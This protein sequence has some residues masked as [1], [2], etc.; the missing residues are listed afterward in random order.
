[1]Q[2]DTLIINGTIIDG[3]CKPKFK[4][5]IGIVNGK[6]DKI[7]QFKEADAKR[8]INAENLIISPGFIDM[9]TH[10]DI[11]L[12]ND[13]YGESKVYQG[14][15]TEVTGNCSYSPFPSGKKGPNHLKKG[16]WETGALA[17]DPNTNWTWN[18]LDD[19]ANTIEKN[20][21]SINIAPQ[22][23]YA[24]L[25]VATGAT[26]ERPASKT[27]MTEMK[28]LA[29]QAI[30]Q[31]AFSISTGLSVPPSAYASTEEVI[32]ICKSISHYNG[33][34]YVTHARVGP[35]KHLSMIEEAVK[36]GQKSN[37]PVQFSHLAI[38]DWRY[39]GHGPNMLK[40]F[41]EADKNGLDITYD[42]YPYTAAGAGLDQMIPLWAQSGGIDTFLE[43]LKNKNKRAQIREEVQEGIGGLAPK[44]ET[45]IL[46]SSNN[47]KN[48]E[49]IGMSIIQIAKKRKIDPAETA[50]QLVEEEIGAVPVTVHNRLESDIRCF[51]DHPLAMFGSDG[52]AVSPNG[53]YKSGRPHPRF[54]G[55]YPRVLGRYV[56]EK[57][58]VLTLEGAIYKMTGFPAKRLCMK[59]RGLIRKGYIADLTIF[60]PKT[61]IDNA[62]FDNPHQYPS[63]I[64]YVFVS[65][66]P[67]IDNGVH[68]N[69]TPG[70]VLRRG[71]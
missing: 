22:L 66:K 26:E 64:P 13:K 23:G 3:A 6:I 2:F 15:T 54:Y 46:S 36:I 31:G 71:N 43:R 55:T 16:L 68:S 53:F 60:D 41:E 12:V 1:M 18:T 42:M 27:E 10:S 65:G 30:E 19:W 51:M 8:V 44:W 61:V 32:E 38:T 5:D 63:G 28:Y 48:K 33:V 69:K 62:T 58:S 49:L 7:G 14:V 67:V 9:H 37:L 11:S 59:N 34:F 40:I 45:V 70:R 35:G 24:A 47:N 20:G 52:N 56:R 21:I 39:Y 29:A 25:Q 17:D 50:L 4:S 57:P